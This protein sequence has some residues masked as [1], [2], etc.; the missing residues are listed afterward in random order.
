M[1]ICLVVVW[2][3]FL[4]FFHPLAYW[5]P[6]TFYL[7]IYRNLLLVN[8][9]VNFDFTSALCSPPPPAGMMWTT[10][11]PPLWGLD[12]VSDVTLL[13]RAV[14]H[15]GRWPCLFQTL[16]GC[17]YNNVCYIVCSLL[18]LSS[19][20]CLV[21]ESVI[22]P[23]KYSTMIYFWHAGLTSSHSAMCKRPFSHFG[24]VGELEEQTQVAH[25]TVWQLLPAILWT[26]A[27]HRSTGQEFL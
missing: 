17:V 18:H 27:F 24:L 15:T 7:C 14:I 13:K 20:D 26:L 11:W 16:M 25:T 21:Y 23:Y 1:S 5:V 19:F 12:N 22:K 8:T 4:R 6:S 10:V 2:W 3:Q 9:Y